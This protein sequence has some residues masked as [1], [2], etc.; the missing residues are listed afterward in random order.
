LRSHGAY[1]GCFARFRRFVLPWWL[2][3]VA[4]LAWRPAAVA[5]GRSLDN[6]RLPA[7]IG[8]GFVFDAVLLVC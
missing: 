2:R 1:L 5:A 7:E 8:G 6:I 3:P 4:R